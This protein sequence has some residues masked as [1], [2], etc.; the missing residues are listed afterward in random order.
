MRGRPLLAPGAPGLDDIALLDTGRR[1]QTPTVHTVD[2]K[3]LGG[4]AGAGQE[5]D[6]GA[7]RDT[8][9]Q[10]PTPAAPIVMSIHP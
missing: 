10:K 1:G 5:C 7:Q 9:P 4:L 3:S 6:R 2:E 8:Q